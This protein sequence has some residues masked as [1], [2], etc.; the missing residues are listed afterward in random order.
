MNLVTACFCPVVN[1]FQFFTVQL[2]VFLDRL[3]ESL[4]LGD[5]LCLQN[6]KCCCKTGQAKR[7]NPALAG[8]GLR[9]V[10]RFH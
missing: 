5:V 6:V 3:K 8:D 4:C 10:I 9:I 2:Q 1:G 7:R